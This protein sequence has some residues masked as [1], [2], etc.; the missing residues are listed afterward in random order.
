MNLLKPLELELTGTTLIEASAGT[1]KTYTITTLFLRLLLEK[2]VSIERILVVTFTIAATEELRIKLSDR[3]HLAHHWLRYPAN[4]DPTEDA[5]LAELITTLDATV[6]LKLIGDAVAR[7]DDLSV[8]TIDALCLRV[9]QDFAFESGLPMRIELIANDTEI[10]R[11]VARDYWRQVMGSNDVFQVENLLALAK[12]P[13]DLLDKLNDVARMREAVC[14]PEYNESDVAGSAAILKSQY[15]EMIRCWRNN[16]KRI[17]EVFADEVGVLSRASYKPESKAEI[18][19]WIKSIMQS[20]HL[21]KKLPARD[22][23]KLI[24]QEWI[25]GKTKKGLDPPTHRFFQLCDGFEERFKHYIKW[26][27]IAAI[28]QAREYLIVH[29][30]RYKS[31]RGLV[32]FEDMR[33]RLDDAL[34]GP[35]G[36]VLAEKIRGLW[37]YGLIDEFQDT[38]AEQ[39]RI[40]NAIYAGQSD[41]G[42][43][44]IGDPKQAVYSWRGA[45]VFTYMSAA[46]SV[47]ESRTLGTNW[48][49]TPAMVAAVNCLFSDREDPFV[50]DQIPFEPVQASLANE[51]LALTVDGQAV[52]P[53]KFNLFDEAELNEAGYAQSKD[54][55]AQACAAEIAGLLNQ[56]AAGTAL[57]NGS[58][59]SSADIAVLVRS[60]REA[61]AMQQALR[62]A[63]VRSVSMPNLTVFKSVEAIDLLMTL[64]AM[65][66]SGREGRVRS[67]LVTS[68]LGFDSSDMEKILCDESEWDRIIGIFIIARE[69]WIER[70]FMHALQ[71]LMLELNIAPRL[72]LNADGE[73]KIT[74]L[75]QLAELLQIQSREVASIEELLH[76]LR[77]EVH[78]SQTGDDALLL[79]LESD[80]GLVQI[81]TMHKSKGLEY[82]VVYIPF[83][84]SLVAGWVKDIVVFHEREALRTIIDLGSDQNAENK[85]LQDEENLSEDLRLLY[86]ALTR[87]K[88]HC[89]MY[90]G[91]VRSAKKTALWYL[92]HHRLG[93][94]APTSFYEMKADLERLASGSGGSVQIAEINLDRIRY[95]EDAKSGELA[96]PVFSTRINQRWGLNS[97]T[98]LLRGED[99]DLPD[100]DEVASE[101]E[102]ETVA[103]AASDAQEQLISSL[104]AGAQTG[105][106][107]HEIY[108]FMD[109]SD[110][111][112]LQILVADS[113]QRY[114]QL[115]STPGE[116]KADWTPAVL[117]I[118]KNTCAANLDS[119]GALQLQS[120]TPK[121]RLNEMEFFF[122]VES[123]DPESLQLA[124]NQ[125]EQYRGVADGLNFNAFEGLM[126]GFIDM[127]VRK[128]KQYFIVDYKSNWL[129]ETVAD[130]SQTAIGHAVR[131][132]RYDLQYLIYTLA[133]HRYLKS[134][135]P[136]YSYDTHFGGVFYLFVRGMRPDS[137][138]GVWNDKPPLAVIEALDQAMQKQQAA[139]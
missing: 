43:F 131:S 10:R 3:L 89:V 134:R 49:S 31:D 50:F 104:P 128:E 85:V 103:V 25:T 124:L 1:G 94:D 113:L 18:I 15:Q 84:G 71:Y 101:S 34:S 55:V 23:F 76:W 81:V 117:E 107:L 65:A 72:L 139:A 75:L 97:Y 62:L 5:V 57:I 120:V 123:L 59:V 45:D 116:K 44:M 54:A 2:R 73:Q 17:L 51:R 108:E 77:N 68:L 78:T 109:F 122:L 114:G 80:E 69:F 61:S 39:Y 42:F 38:D 29:I 32:H 79:R 129:G 112:D 136:G 99:A 47:S 126:Q 111:S 100:H 37:P 137:N 33:T 96:L 26:Q 52:V 36:S 20:D 87:A 125:F 135:V 83:P 86:V 30:D 88:S 27:R 102:I 64:E 63:G 56:G 119:E 4:V 16:S 133:L 91:N 98:G 41:C 70:G 11:E 48:R 8:Y 53:M 66:Y 118:I 19:S 138:T 60:H 95:R 46:N 90:W 13:D 132:H 110:L 14:I 58:P 24:T 67:A 9:L 92:I 115:S 22:R 93:S 82:P 21:P 121:D 40:F 7:L 74:N 28:I 130:Y 106:L 6:A 35:N 127:V 12:T 105:Q